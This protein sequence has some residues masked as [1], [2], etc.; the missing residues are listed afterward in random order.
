MSTAP[1]AFTQ[2]IPQELSD[3]RREPR[4]YILANGY[5]EPLDVKFTNNLITLPADGQFDP[6]GRSGLFADGT[7]I[8]SSRTLVDEFGIVEVTGEEG[9]TFNAERAAIHILGIQKG[10]TGKMI[11]T[12]SFA[13][14]GVFLVPRGS[15]QAQFKQLLEQAR[16]RA[17][18]A[19]VQRAYTLVESIDAANAVRRNRGDM[20]LPG[21]PEYDKARRIIEAANEAHGAVAA[22]LTNSRLEASVDE[23]EIELI[24]HV[25]AIALKQAEK[26][27]ALMGV[28]KTKLFEA[29]LNDPEVR[30]Y[31]RKTKLKIRRQGH[32][33]LPDPERPVDPNALAVAVAQMQ[34]E[35][36]AALAGA[37]D[38][39]G[40][41]DGSEIPDPEAAERERRPELE[42]K[43]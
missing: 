35:D 7:P 20:P 31:A 25:R 4:T 32:Q 41:L 28:D 11:C 29:L 1:T 2:T 38:A 34:Q 43:G 8:P 26:T 27:A 16:E 15:T 14:K 12:S 40:G 17:K 3:F 36:E 33:G 23:E 39:P 5:H 24:A 6:A 9:F 22:Q 10:P 42:V 30:A 18:A 37:A 13:A 19:D 21:G